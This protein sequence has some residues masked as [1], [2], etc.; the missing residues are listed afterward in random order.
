MPKSM[1]IANFAAHCE[2]DL[3][4]YNKL[5][6]QKQTDPNND[7]YKSLPICIIDAVFSIGV[8]YGS[9]KKATESFLSYFHLTIPRTCP[10]GKEYTVE[11][12]LRDMGTFSSFEDAATNGFKNRQRTSSRNG[13]LKAE[14][15]YLVASVLKEHNINTLEDFQTYANRAKLDADIC[16]VKGQ[17]SGIMN[18][19]L[20]ML[21]GN[22]NEIKP[23]RHLCRYVQKYFPHL[24][25]TPKDFPTIK[26]ILED[27]ARRLGAKYPSLTPRFLDYLIWDYM[28]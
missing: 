8:R 9:V 10:V 14:A 24:S 27:T 19:Y 2:K 26:T 20:W 17:H 23:D 16:A 7:F 1:T 6:V 22:A 13:I 25:A 12:F 5:T 3:D 18:R 15:C 28:R 21:A 11:N 4:F